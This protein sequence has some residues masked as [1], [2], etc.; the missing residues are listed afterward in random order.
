MNFN[1]GTLM[2]AGG[3]TLFIGLYVNLVIGLFGYLIRDQCLPSMRGDF[4]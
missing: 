3:D 4:D 1:Q 2:R